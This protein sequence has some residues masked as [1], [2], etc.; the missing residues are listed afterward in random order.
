MSKVKW[1][2]GK[3]AIIKSQN[4][5]HAKASGI[6]DDYFQKISFRTTY[7]HWSFFP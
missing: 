4:Y 3:V 1:L 7:K 5:K 2:L 6:E